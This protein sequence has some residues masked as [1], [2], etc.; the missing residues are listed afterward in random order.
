MNSSPDAVKAS[1]PC[2]EF[3]P[4]LEGFPR[5]VSDRLAYHLRYGTLT[6]PPDDP[7]WGLIDSYLSSMAVAVGSQI[8]KSANAVWHRRIEASWVGPGLSNAPYL[9]ATTSTQFLGLRA[10]LLINP[11]TL[12][13]RIGGLLQSR[14][15]GEG[16]RGII[17]KL[18]KK[19]RSRLLELTRELEASDIYPELMIT[20]TYPRDWEGAISPEHA[21][22]LWEFRQAWGKLNAHR[23]RPKAPGW[24]ERWAELRAEVRARLRR[25]REVGPDGKKVKAHLEAFRKR[26]ERRFGTAWGL[27]W[28]LEFQKRGAPHI[29]L[30]LW[31]CQD[32]DPGELRA[33]IG[34]AWAEVVAGSDL[35]AYFD[36]QNLAL[37]DAYREQGGREFAEAMLD[38]MGLS[39]GTWNHIR[40][41]TGVEI[42]REKHWGYLAKE[43]QGGMNKAYQ[44]AVPRRYRNVGRWWGYW[45]YKR[46]GWIELF[47]DLA[48]ASMHE[49]KE[50]IVKPVEAA[51]KTLPKACKDFKERAKAMLT[52]FLKTGSLAAQK[53][54]PDG[55]V[56]E[57]AYGYLTVWGRA[58]VQAAMGVL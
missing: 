40:A 19:S 35:S 45:R 16:V 33:W 6:L 44:H 55:V 53:V 42:L 36:P 51:V 22:A 52:R 28:K 48:S 24:A 7:R 23:Y 26:F 32:I 56:T 9:D 34:R 46:A 30:F 27:I 10:R 20:L 54:D 39:T 57:G 1:R 25:L 49:I 31:N 12:K 29:H 8:A 14:L 43:I 18:S 3:S 13:L 5:P 17:R 38:G 37:Y 41:G 2:P 4:K 21:T 11:G 58:G 47:Y 15:G 50:A